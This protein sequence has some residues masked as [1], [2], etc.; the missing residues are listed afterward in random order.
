M[1]KM[2]PLSILIASLT[3]GALA[4]DAQTKYEHTTSLNEQVTHQDRL[5]L[6]SGSYNLVLDRDEG[7]ATESG[8]PHANFTLNKNFN[9]KTSK[10]S[11][12]FTILDGNLDGNDIFDIGGWVIQDYGRLSLKVDAEV[13]MKNGFNP[14][15][16]L[17]A[18]Y[19]Y[20]NL[21]GELS[22]FNDG[23]MIGWDKREFLGW[24]RFT[25][26]HGYF[27]LGKDQEKPHIFL[28]TRNFDNVGAFLRANYNADTGAWV[29]KL[30]AGFGNI[31]KNFFSD[32]L[33]DFASAYFSIPKFLPVHFSPASQ[34]GVV[35]LAFD[36]FGNQDGTIDYTAKI[37]SN[38]FPIQPMIGVTKISG[39]NLAGIVELYAPVKIAGKNIGLELLYNGGTDTVELYFKIR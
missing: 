34:K 7:R 1:N 30:K 11:G 26:E 22:V 35:A 8:K 25:T 37:G 16:F 28:G 20:E 13:L 27:G 32:K 39:Q 15:E 36:A 5:D 3:S 2:I 23:E 4:Q 24:T 17:L 31:D 6:T 10:K 14:A 18:A 38:L 29:A 9:I 19:T 12:A 21:S 33:Y